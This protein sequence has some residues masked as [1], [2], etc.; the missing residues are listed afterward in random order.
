MPRPWFVFSFL[1]LFASLARAQTEK[2]EEAARLFKDGQA[3]YAGGKFAEAAALFERANEVEPHAAVMFNAALAWE[4]AGDLPRSADDFESALAGQLDE[5]SKRRAQQ[6]L[7][8]IEQTVG[9][10][11]IVAPAGARVVIGQRMRSNFP[12]RVHVATGLV[13]VRVTFPDGSTDS[14]SVEVAA[15][16]TRDLT[17]SAPAKPPP[18]PSKK[19]PA[20]TSTSV[21]PWPIAGYVSLGVASSL[22]LTSVVLWS[23]AKDERDALIEGDASARG[24]AETLQTWTNVTLV[25]SVV[26]ASAGVTI[27]VL[28]PGESREVGELRLRIGR[29]VSLLGSF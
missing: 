20:P 24:R 10:I 13:D 12:T 25:S 7:R 27:L 21:N 2:S 11:R 15:G 1:L 4:R 28:R 17:L 19:Q 26:L 3:R 14:R 6:R 18:T 5:A 23:N 22:M 9:V 16:E 8:E 29:E